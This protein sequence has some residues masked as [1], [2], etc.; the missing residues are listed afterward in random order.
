MTC[1]V[2]KFTVKTLTQQISEPGVETV[3]TRSINTN[4]VI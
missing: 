4:V 1:H 3:S 2:N